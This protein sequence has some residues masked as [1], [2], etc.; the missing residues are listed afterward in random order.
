MQDNK[1]SF[2]DSKSLIAIGF[3]IVSWLAW[4]HYM[5]KKISTRSQ[6]TASADEGVGRRG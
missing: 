2:L 4:D 5:K 6:G 1:E 3:L